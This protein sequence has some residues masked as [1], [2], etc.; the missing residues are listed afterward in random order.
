MWKESL[1]ATGTEP[2]I[3]GA[4]LYHI[5]D[6]DFNYQIQKRQKGLTWSRYVTLIDVILSR[7]YPLEG[8][9]V[10]IQAVTTATVQQASLWQASFVVKLV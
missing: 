5:I 3:L 8:L 4:V 6:F 10:N 9:P 1:N 7:L 2:I